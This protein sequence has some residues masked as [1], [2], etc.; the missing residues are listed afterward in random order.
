MKLAALDLGSNSFLCLI[1][2]I[3]QMGQLTVEHD[4]IR[5]V[6]LGEGLSQSKTFHPEALQR[7]DQALGEFAQAI[8]QA[9]CDHVL[10][11]AT[12]AARDAKNKDDFFYICQKHS[13]PVEI[14]SGGQEAQLTYFGALCDVDGLPTLGLRPEAFQLVI[15]IGG[16][17][18]EF[19]LGK[20][21][22]VQFAQSVNIGCVGLTEKLVRR[23]PLSSENI[24]QIQ[25][26][27]QSSIFQPLQEIKKIIGGSE[28]D[29]VAVAGTPTSLATMEVGAYDV[30]RIEGFVLTEERVQSYAQMLAQLSPS[31][32]Q[33]NYQIDPKRADVIYIGAEVLCQ[34]SS[35]V[36]SF[37]LQSCQIKVSTKGIRYGAMIELMKR[38]TKISR[39]D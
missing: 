37:T 29:V 18:T 35:S 8:Q 10:G 24:T 26:E 5:V 19:V 33:Q 30:S 28:L 34:I 27:I 39:K 1:G 15:D 21:D 20:S 17:S 3:D 16:R 6:R 36:S 32:I 11:F 9:G 13:L 14:I 7:A 2:S 38:L 4:L 12:A 23:Q 25:K 31:Q 22:Q